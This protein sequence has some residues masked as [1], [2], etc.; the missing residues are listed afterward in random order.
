MQNIQNHKG[1][2]CGIQ[3]KTQ[4]R[5]HCAKV[6]RV[7]PSFIKITDRNDGKDYVYKKTSIIN[8]QF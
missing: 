7:T 5:V 1:R 3:T 8:V 6:F 2:F 4:K